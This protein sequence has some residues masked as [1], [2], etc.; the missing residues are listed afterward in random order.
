[1]QK[2]VCFAVSTHQ[3]GCMKTSLPQ[4]QKPRKEK[5]D[6]MET[7][8]ARHLLMPLMPS[9]ILLP[10]LSSQHQFIS[11]K[12]MTDLIDHGFEESNINPILLNKS[13]NLANLTY[14]T[15]ES[16]VATH[17]PTFTH[18]AINTQDLCSYR[19]TGVGCE[20]PDKPSGPSTPIDLTSFEGFSYPKESPTVL[21]L[22]VNTKRRCH[23]L[24]K[25]RKPSSKMRP[26]MWKRFHARPHWT[27][28][29]WHISHT[30]Y[31]NM[32][33]ERLLPS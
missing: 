20:Q 10:G 2:H 9:N 17:I 24:C 29:I 1:M 19:K 14:T 28:H 8:C 25:A 13:Q 23:V 5:V 3:N 6:K 7:Q 21:W 11:P 4:A 32:T 27:L 26:S 16:A 33:G 15:I 31:L 30:T 22:A 12:L 18:K